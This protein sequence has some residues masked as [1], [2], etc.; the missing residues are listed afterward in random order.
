ME[1]I[2]QQGIRACNV[3]QSVVLALEEQI[4]NAKLVREQTSSWK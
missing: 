4:P 2:Y 3:I 1:I